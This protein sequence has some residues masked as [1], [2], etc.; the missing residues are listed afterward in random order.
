MKWLWSWDLLSLYVFFLKNLFLS[1]IVLAFFTSLHSLSGHE[2]RV[3]LFLLVNILLIATSHLT[4]LGMIYLMSQLYLGM[5]PQLELPFFNSRADKDDSRCFNCGSY[6]HAL[7]ECPKPRDNAAINNARKQHNMKRNQSNVNR[8]QNR[9]YQKT[10][11][12]FDD[13]RPGILGPE[14]REC[15]GI[16]VIDDFLCQLMLELYWFWLVF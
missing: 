10:P 14:T 13:L 4:C 8:G 5:N 15:L 12:K 2:L 3:P 7:K 1:F 6:S 16:G 9:Y 11:G